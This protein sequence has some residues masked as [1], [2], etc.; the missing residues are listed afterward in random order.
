MIELVGLSPFQGTAEALSEVNDISEGILSDFLRATLEA[1]LPKASKKKG[2]TLG[3]WEKNLAGSIKAAFPGISC[4][5]GDTNA[6]C[7]DLLR[8]LRQHGD[9]LIKQL[10]PG[11]IERSNLGLGHAY[12]RSKV[13]FSISRHDYPIVQSIA[14]LD[15]VDKFLNTFAMKL[16]ENYGWHF[17]ELNKIVSGNEQYAKL[18]LKIRNKAD[19]S[20]DDLHDLAAEVGD[21]EGVAQAIINAA[22]SS[23]GRDLSE[24]D[25]EMVISFAERTASLA[26]YR[27]HLSGYLSSKMGAVAVRHPPSSQD[28]RIGRV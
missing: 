7:A 23:M 14:T 5:T 24:A 26:A 17:P 25:M 27:K 11:D 6:V 12:S 8:G 19:L 22:R 9:K 16:R 28:G 3:V 15:D 1:N 18:V 20:D 4:E 10:Q 21:D 2:I 13:K